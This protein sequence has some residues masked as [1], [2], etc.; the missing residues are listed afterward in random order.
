[1]KKIRAKDLAWGDRFLAHG[2]LWT[3]TDIS[4][5]WIVAR[6]HGPESTALGS[7]GYGY[8]GDQICSFKPGEKVVFVPVVWPMDLKIFA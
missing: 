4:P 5:E 8:I 6:K 1:M 2:S 3:V 7:K